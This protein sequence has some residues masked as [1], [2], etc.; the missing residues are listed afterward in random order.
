MFSQPTGHDGAYGL[1]VEG[2]SG[3]HRVTPQHGAVCAVQANHLNS[4]LQRKSFHWDEV[5][6]SYKLDDIFEG[7]DTCSWVAWSG[8]SGE[9][10][11]DDLSSFMQRERSR[12]RDVGQPAPPLTPEEPESE[13]PLES[14]DDEQP[15]APTSSEANDVAWTLVWCNMTVEPISVTAGAQG[16][17]TAAAAQAAGLP[18]AEVV[19]LHP[20]HSLIQTQS[21]YVALLHCRG[22]YVHE[23]SEAVTLFDIVC[24]DDQMAFSYSDEPHVFH[25][26]H[27]SRTWL[28][29]Y[30]FAGTMR[31]TNLLTLM[32]KCAFFTMG[33]GGQP[34]MKVFV[35]FVMVIISK[36]YVMTSTTRNTVATCVT[37]FEVKV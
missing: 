35:A 34:K 26:H 4:A 14:P 19:A 23:G 33:K 15:K 36:W 17:T 25:S 20:V 12:S 13:A 11:D 30:S 16:P 21:A 10:Q 9:Q 1:G 24:R 31:L 27:I 28:T 2:N 3:L 8:S 18:I 22:D 37:G 6:W 32:N 7:A 5:P 29:F